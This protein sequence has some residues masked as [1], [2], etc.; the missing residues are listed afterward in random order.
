MSHRDDLDWLT[1]EAGLS[2]DVALELSAIFDWAEMNR[3]VDVYGYAKDNADV[4]FIAE[5]LRDSRFVEECREL[6][7][8]PDT[9][10][11]VPAFERALHCASDD[12]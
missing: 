8:E 3:A 7:A 10:A 5:R 4:P 6:L 11:L 9:T 1:E 2:E 12:S